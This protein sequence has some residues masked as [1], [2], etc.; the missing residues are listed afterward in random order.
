MELDDLKQT[1]QQ[2]PIKKN[3]NTD[4]MDL[5]LH[6]SYG[7]VTALKRA[8]RKEII[9]M[10]VLP[11]LILLSNVGNMD[12]TL[13]SILFWS[14]VAFCIGVVVFASFSYR[15]VLKMEDMSGSVRANLERQINVLET[16]L[17]WNRIGIRIA[18]LFFII[19][20]EILPYFQHYRM[21]DKWHSLSPAIRFGTYAALLLLQYF[22]SR[23]VMERKFGAHLTYLKQVV[24]EMQY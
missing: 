12:A 17:K 9:V 7:P 6:K 11:V 23:K 2:T 22:V 5:L 8:F 4:I 21:L 18:L 10:L 20:T 3:I 15:I 24:K 16:R 14:Y 13:T 1:W 19:L